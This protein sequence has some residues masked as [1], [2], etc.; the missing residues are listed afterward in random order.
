LAVVPEARSPAGS[1]TPSR[2]LPASLVGLLNLARPTLRSAQGLS[3]QS[4]RSPHTIAAMMIPVR[5]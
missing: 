2:R 1:S 3:G 4:V 5:W